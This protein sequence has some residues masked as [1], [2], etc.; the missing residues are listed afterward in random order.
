MVRAISLK[1]L[2][3]SFISVRILSLCTGLFKYVVGHPIE[4]VNPNQAKM[5][6]WFSSVLPTM[7][8]GVLI[9]GDA[10][11]FCYHATNPETTIPVYTL[12]V[13]L[14]LFKLVTFQ[15]LEPGFLIRC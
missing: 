8:I 6:N 9:D 2:P 14:S 7:N 12:K 5:G 15:G 3:L 1:L 4:L 13:T 11:P 10:S